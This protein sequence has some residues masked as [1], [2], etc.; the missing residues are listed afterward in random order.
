M[1]KINKYFV[2]F[3][4]F[5]AAPLFAH[6]AVIKIEGEN[7]YKSLRLTPP[8]YNAAHK[9]LSDILIKD[10]NGE[11]VPYFIN[12]SVQNKNSSRQ[13]YPLT[14]INSYVKDEYFFFDYK[15][16]FS[17]DGDIIANFLEFLTN[18][19]GFAK[20]VDVF[21]SYDDINWDFVQNDMLYVVEGKS[22]LDVFFHRPQKYTHYR[23]RIANNMER[24]SFE[25]VNLVFN[26]EIIDETYFIESFVPQFTVENEDGKT[27][28]IIEG[29]KNL[30]L[31]DLS[32]ETNSMFIR[33][34]RAPQGIAK[35]LY[36]LS[37]N[38]TQY[39]DIVLPL[40]RRISQDEKYVVTIDDGDDKPIDVKGIVVRYF[41]DDIVFQ[42]SAGNVHTLEF[43]DTSRAAPVYDIQ[44][45]KT[46][47]LKEP[48][49]KLELGEIS[50]VQQSPERDEISVRI[51]FNIAVTLVALALGVVIV[52]KLKK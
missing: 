26:K 52:L 32:I 31:C 49:D 44:R 46:E 19:T 48:I 39:K 51:I 29:L 16:S 17:Q 22:K 9:N 25:R 34:V 13:T 30:R 36:N 41:A 45:Y 43:S 7:I 2:L 14:L 21:G 3:T 23:F 4:C 50:Y 40:N 37:I 18:N 15:L 24:I 6:N 47:I 12:S 20:R 35:E 28:I 1:R 5:S 27:K 33:T 8:V 38:S 10:E 11:N 42:K